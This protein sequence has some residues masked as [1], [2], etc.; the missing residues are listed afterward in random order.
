MYLFLNAGRGATLLSFT[1]LETLSCICSDAGRVATTLPGTRGVLRNRLVIITHL[2][3]HIH[4]LCSDAGRVATT[5]PSRTWSAAQ[6]E[7]KSGHLESHCP[8]LPPRYE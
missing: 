2:L 5:L 4:T 7:A 3:S 8:A 6:Q 1:R